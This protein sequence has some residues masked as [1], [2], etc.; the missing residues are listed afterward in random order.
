ML[1]IVQPV[2]HGCSLMR[3]DMPIAQIDL[4]G[5]LDKRDKSRRTEHPNPTTKVG[6]NR[7]RGPPLLTPK[8]RP[9]RVQHSLRPFGIN[10]VSLPLRLELRMK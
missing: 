6:E 2:A 3:D 4:Y 1:A 5:S 8:S 7:G 10:T 9:K